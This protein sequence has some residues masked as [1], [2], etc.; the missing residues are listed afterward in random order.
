MTK[1]V[2][3]MFSFR[4]VGRV[5]MDA[6]TS[7]VLWIPGRG[8]EEERHQQTVALVHPMAKVF[9]LGHRR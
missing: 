7:R 5:K 1:F 9:N 3:L 8:E 4:M 2:L 6:I